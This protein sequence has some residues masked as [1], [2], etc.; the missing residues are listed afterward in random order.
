MRIPLF[1]RLTAGIFL[2]FSIFSASAQTFTEINYTGS[3]IPIFTAQ[4]VN[5]LAGNP[6]VDGYTVQPLSFFWDPEFDGTNLELISSMLENAATGKTELSCTAIGMNYV[7]QPGYTYYVTVTYF[8][9]VLNTHPGFGMSVGTPQLTNVFAQTGS[10]MTGRYGSAPS[11]IT[12]DNNFLANTTSSSFVTIT[13]TSAYSTYTFPSFSVGA[14]TTGLNLEV[15]PCDG[16]VT[17]GMEIANIAV[18]GVPAISGASL[19]CTSQAFSVA[20]SAGWPV[21]WSITPAIASV[22]S[23]GNTATVTKTAASGST[24]LSAVYSAPNGL[25]Y[26]TDFPL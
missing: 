14:S 10:A 18:V 4:G 24:T 13:S 2:F 25:H 6:V 17:V 11:N 23:S 19:V 20:N 16:N 12:L 21:T 7:F 8:G 1:S 22:S 15:L 26:E 9:N 5:V 3:S